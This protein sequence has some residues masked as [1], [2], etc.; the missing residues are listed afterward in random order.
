MLAKQDLDPESRVRALI[1][2][3]EP[4]LRTAFI[5]AIEQVRDQTTLDMLETLIEQ[6]RFQEALETAGN[7]GILYA[8]AVNAAFVTAGQD[9]AGFMRQRLGRVIGFDN[10]ADRAVRIMRANNLRLVREFTIEQTITTQRALADGIRR[11]I[12]PRAQARLFRD[13][14]GLTTRQLEAVENYR[15]A[16]EQNSLTS[17]TRELRDRRFDPTVRRAARTGD[18]LSA[19]QIER[20]TDRYRQR[21]LAHRAEVIARTEALRSVHEG[22]DEMYEQA[23]ASG[24]VDPTQ[25]MR[26]WHTAADAR[27]RDSHGPMDG[28]QRPVGEP[29]LSGNG[30][31]L[32]F[33]GDP[34]APVSET[35]QCR[36][37]VSTTIN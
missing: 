13:S 4:R 27:V 7:A 26:T 9:T 1:A 5:S 36:C 2:S 32:R 6:G 17:L 28:Q 10:A 14:I 30:N 18:P 29:F 24:A 21:F 31:P 12:N 35:A 16:L 11:G 3:A 37:A 25:V 33:P 22:V 15:R 8:G 20:M 23:F 34:N 19:T